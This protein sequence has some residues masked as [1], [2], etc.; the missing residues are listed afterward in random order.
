VQRLATDRSDLAGDAAPLGFATQGAAPAA[1]PSAGVAPASQ[2]LKLDELLVGSGEDAAWLDRLADDI[3]LLAD[4]DRREAQVRLSPRALG[5][6]GVR[7]EL[8]GRAAR[9]HFTVETAAAQGMIADNSSRLVQLVEAN[10]L[11]LDGATVDLG[12]RRDDREGAPQ[13]QPAP[14]FQRAPRASA[15]LIE[16]VARTRVAT[17]AERFA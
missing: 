3:K 17:A 2:P 6:M 14:E 4:G 16:A 13:P 11:K 7:L 12:S 10:G 1:A 5:D 8:E 9:V 15:T